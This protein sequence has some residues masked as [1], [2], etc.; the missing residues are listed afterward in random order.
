MPKPKA[1]GIFKCEKTIML[2][3]KEI[4]VKQGETYLVLDVNFEAIPPYALV[5]NKA[6]DRA[7]FYPVD[8]FNW[9]K[10]YDKY[11]AIGRSV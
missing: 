8:A 9:V 3:N 11:G 4:G 2:P 10:N 7:A 5:M 6:N 1:I